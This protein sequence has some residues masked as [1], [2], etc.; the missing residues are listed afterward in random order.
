MFGLSGIILPES[1][2]AYLGRLTQYGISFG[3]FLMED[4]MY[5][6][7]AMCTAFLIIVLALPNSVQLKERFKP[8]AGTAIFTC[9]IAL[10]AILMLTKVSEFLYFNF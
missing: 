3:G 2:Y 5:P 7:L 9:A 1:T 10:T 4:Y 8:N 6:A